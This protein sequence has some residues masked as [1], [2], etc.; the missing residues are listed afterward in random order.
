M[1]IIQK[2]RGSIYCNQGAWDALNKAL[3]QV[4]PSNIFV[5]TDVNTKEHCL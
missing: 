4:S 5:L 3:N 1:R 2:D